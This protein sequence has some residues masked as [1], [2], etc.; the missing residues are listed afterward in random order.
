MTAER[1]DLLVIDDSGV[2]SLTL[3]AN[4]HADP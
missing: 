4:I 3:S 1:Q 2:E